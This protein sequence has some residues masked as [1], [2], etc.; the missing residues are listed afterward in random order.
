MKFGFRGAL[1]LLSVAWST[2]AMA[3]TGSIDLTATGSSTAVVL[4]WTVTDLTTA[5]QE[6][7]RNT[8]SD[9]TGRARIAVAGTSARTYSDA[10]AVAGT[11]YYYWI[12]NTTSGVVT[13]SNAASG[14]LKSSS[15]SSSSSSAASGSISLTAT[16]AVGGVVLS[17]SVSNLTTST[18]QIYRG[19]DSTF[20]NSAL[21]ATA[22][23]TAR[24]YTDSTGVVG[25][26][27]IYWI[28]NTTSGTVTTSNGAS[29]TA[30]AASSS[31]SSSS[32]S[33]SSKASSSAV[34][35]SS[36]KSSVASSSSSSASSGR[37]VEKLGRG[38]VAVPASS[39]MLVSWRLLGTD[40]SGIG[41]NVYR[42]GSK[43]NSSVITTST[44]YNDTAG[45]SASTYTVVPV[46]GS[47]EQTGSGA[48]VLANPYLKIAISQPAGGT[49]PDGVAYT[50]EANDG[51]V[52]DLDGDGEYEI[53]LKWQPTNAKDNSQSGYT[54]PTIVDAYKLNGTRLWRINLGKNIRAGAH[55]T[56]IVAYDLDSDGK[57]EVMMKTADGTVDGAGTV[58][59][60][61]TADYRNSKGYI[62]TGPEYLT[63]FNG[64]TGAAMATTNYL[65]ARGTVSSWGDSYGNRVDRFLAGVA[66]LDGT[67]PSAVFS[68][69]YYTRAVVVAWD[70][71]DGKLTSRWTYDSGSTKGVGA[72][73]EGA[74]WF[75][76]ADVN[77]DGKDDIIY[78]AAV[79]KNDGSLLYRTGMGHGDAIHVGVLN[80]NRTGEQV[81][82]VHE[83]DD[84]YGANHGM[85]MHDA[86]TG[87][88]L[89][90]Y[91]SSGDVGRGVCAD[92]DPAYPGEECWSTV[93]YVLMSSSGVTISSTK[94]PS[95][96]NFAVWWDG[97]LS[98][99]LLDDTKIDKWVPSSLST[100]R[101][102][103]A[104]N[105]GA[106]SNNSTKATPVISADIFGDWREE[107]V[108]RTSDN[109]ALLL[110]TSPYATTYRIPT[111]MHD[112]Q[113]RV[114]VAGQN[115]G[116]NQ[117]PHPS[118]FLGNGMG[119]VTLPAIRTP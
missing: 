81:F 48:T 39:G 12:K 112:P 42:N 73:G 108:W 78:G 102:L 44:N 46:I 80:P 37:Y 29:G 93:G 86:A 83:D 72:Y 54:G 99:E 34:S 36:S 100:T 10:T 2:L 24:T 5:T 58:I 32:S 1:A 90:G 25:T 23:S 15:S 106:A 75:S 41:F 77:R 94:R 104:Y 27:Y 51:T 47:V 110:F 97:D 18:Q 115:M 116:Y 28:K 13:N 71:R 60:S 65:P 111:L 20:A 40:P 70:W 53:I 69:G 56:S 84:V 119:A 76:V 96:V 64:K 105:Y 21:I 9:A 26:K 92:I 82:M 118:F 61:S 3:A 31:S 85:E 17:W 22:A 49:T 114:Q 79:I 33:T 11:K 45:T 43:L 66:Y 117:P 62:L 98:R 19:A 88:V 68:R 6:V 103:T 14:Q 7:Y 55:Y 87:A 107:V 63:V 67:R 91:G 4:T 109:T 101:L 89:W 35:S 52:A 30:R 8:T 57:A 113:Y 16:G 95:P 38:V 59:G 50:Y 74:H